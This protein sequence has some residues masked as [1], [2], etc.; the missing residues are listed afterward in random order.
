MRERGYPASFPANAPRTTLDLLTLH[1]LPLTN[2]LPLRNDT[3]ERLL[4]GGWPPASTITF[5]TRGCPG[6]PMDLSRYRTWLLSVLCIALPLIAG[7]AGS[8]FT[9]GSIP[10][11]YAGLTKPAINPPGWIFGPVWTLL[12]ILMGISL[13]LVLKEGT[14]RPPV[15]QSAILFLAQLTLNLLWSAVF[16]GLHAIATALVVLLLLIVFIAATAISFRRI[17]APAAW[18]LV[19]YLAWCCFAALLNAQI[20]LLNGIQA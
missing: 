15:R 6:T 2:P 18:L 8:Y 20:W 10:G 19:P 14:E 17:S 12:Y 4:E 3:G 9:A 13:Y 7:L 16:F 1:H 5:I 11:W